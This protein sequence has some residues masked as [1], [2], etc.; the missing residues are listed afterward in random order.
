MWGINGLCLIPQS[1]VISRLVFIMSLTGY[2]QTI[3]DAT[4]YGFTL[5]AFFVLF[6][7]VYLFGMFCFVF[8]PSM[9]IY[10]LTIHIDTEL[11]SIEIVQTSYPIL[12]V[13]LM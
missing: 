5:F 2:H 10:I 12:Y 8:F 4:Q 7:V 9:M 6:F 11:E 13:K 1:P 3:Q